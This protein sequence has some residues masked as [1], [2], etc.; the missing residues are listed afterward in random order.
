VV[1]IRNLSD[2]SEREVPASHLLAEVK[3][4]LSGEGCGRCHDHE[5]QH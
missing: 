2:R 3:A 5:H 4:S 1:K